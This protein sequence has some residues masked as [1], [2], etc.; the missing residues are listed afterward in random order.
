VTESKSKAVPLVPQKLL[1]DLKE[2]YLKHVDTTFWLDVP[3]LMEE[4]REVLNSES[5]LFT[6]V[7]L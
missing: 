2:A 7:Y 5:N 1:E 4:R 3:T 6:D